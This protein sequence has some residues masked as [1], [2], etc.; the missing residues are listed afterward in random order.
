[1]RLKTTLPETSTLRGIAF[2]P[3]ACP[4][5]SGSFPFCIWVLDFG[6]FVHENFKKKRQETKKGFQLMS[7]SCYGCYRA[8]TRLTVRIHGPLGGMVPC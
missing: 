4:V 6:V 3:Y 5:A 8:S 7:R 2:C 1:M